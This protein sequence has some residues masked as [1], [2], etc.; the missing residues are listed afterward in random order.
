MHSSSR[1]RGGCLT[2]GR[3]VRL[4]SNV[5]KRPSTNLVVVREASSDNQQVVLPAQPWARG[6]W[7][8]AGE[9]HRAQQPK[10]A[11]H[12]EAAKLVAVGP[13]VRVLLRAALGAYVDEAVI[14]LW[15]QEFGRRKD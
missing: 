14:R 1:S 5:T 3:S 15:M 7:A 6:L 9:R 11:R 10:A 8:G 13:A 12:T 4:H 2:R